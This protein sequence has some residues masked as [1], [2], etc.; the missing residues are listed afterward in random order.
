VITWAGK[1]P[2]YFSDIGFCVPPS[3]SSNKCDELGNDRW[4][5]ESISAAYQLEPPESSVNVGDVVDVVP[6]FAGGRSRR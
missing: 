6:A 2:R 4:W 5:P 3:P 1:T